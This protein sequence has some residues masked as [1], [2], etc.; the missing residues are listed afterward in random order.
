MLGLVFSVEALLLLL[1]PCGSTRTTPGARNEADLRIPCRKH[2]YS[3][4]N[5]HQGRR[6][7][8]TQRRY[9]GTRRP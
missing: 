5:P 6:D 2:R 8:Q 7:V 3:L 9:L 1:K 4:Q